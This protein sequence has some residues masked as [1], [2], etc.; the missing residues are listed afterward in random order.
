MN[1]AFSALAVASSFDKELHTITDIVLCDTE[2]EAVA[3]IIRQVKSN[4]PYCQ[5]RS[6][7]ARELDMEHLMKDWLDG[8]K[9]GDNYYK[10]KK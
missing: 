5:V 9:T 3:S 10:D 1:K 2:E 6:A 7:V 4:Y 8:K